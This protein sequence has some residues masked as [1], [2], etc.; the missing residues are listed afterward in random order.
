MNP[1]WMGWTDWNCQTNND[2]IM[3]GCQKDGP[4]F[5]KL[6]GLCPASNIDT[7]WTVQNEHGLYFLHGIQSSE[8][9]YDSENLKWNLKVYGKKQHTNAFSEISYNSFLLGKS[10]WLLNNDTDSK[11][12]IQLDSFIHH[13]ISDCFKGRVYNKTLKLSGCAD[14][15]F[16][17]SDGQCVK[18][19]DRCDQILDCRDKSDEQ[20]CKILTL[21][22]GYNNIIPP[23]RL[24]KSIFS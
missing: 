23:F 22:D 24:V 12:S 8:I 11:S 5:L 21:K 17:C 18:I 1:N 6:R 10:D 19:R 13:I 4:V 9:R 16:T 2:P 3:C 14:D 15:E 7:F 20:D